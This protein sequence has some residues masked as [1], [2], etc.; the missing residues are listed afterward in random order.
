MAKIAVFF[1]KDLL[2]NKKI[3]TSSVDINWTLD[4]AG[5]QKKCFWE[6]F[7]EKKNSTLGALKKFIAQGLPKNA[8]LNVTTGLGKKLELLKIAEMQKKN[9]EAQSVTQAFQ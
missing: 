6:N 3:P 5:L 4:I 8:V 2:W 9:C 7:E 1:T